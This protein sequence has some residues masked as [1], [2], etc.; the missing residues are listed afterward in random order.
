MTNLSIVRDF[1]AQLSHADDPR[2]HGWPVA[3]IPIAALGV[4]GA[5]G[6]LSG[7]GVTEPALAV[8]HDGRSL[9]IELRQ[10]TASARQLTSDLHAAGV[11]GRVTAIPTSSGHVGRWIAATRGASA[12]DSPLPLAPGAKPSSCPDLL[13][14]EPIREAV[15]SGTTLT[16]PASETAASRANVVLLVGRPAQSSTE[17][18]YD[19]SIPHNGDGDVKLHCI[20]PGATS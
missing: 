3:A 18:F 8:S 1:G 12:T 19:A 16:L 17:P 15:I 2:R 11:P 10:P 14:G 7:G 20:S 13:A 5:L 6:V 9:V 4:A